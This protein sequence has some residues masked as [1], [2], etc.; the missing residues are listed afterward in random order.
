M[1]FVSRTDLVPEFASVAFNL[2]STE[3]V[4]RVVETEYGFH[5][6]QLIE[7]KGNMMNFRHILLTPAVSIDQIQA[8]ETKAEEVYN[9]IATDSLTFDMA[10]NN[11][12]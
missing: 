5:I 8:A 4:S 7:K 12:V 3:D 9:L 2:T 1:G 11:F 6:I 10:R